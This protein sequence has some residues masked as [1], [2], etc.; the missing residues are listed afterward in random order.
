MFFIAVGECSG[1]SR[2]VRFHGL[3]L[4]LLGLA[5]GF[6]QAQGAADA[7]AV[8]ALPEVI[9]GAAHDEFETAD[10]LPLSHDTVP[11]DALEAGQARSV[12]QALQDLPNVSVRE[13][14]AR[15]GVSAASSAFARDG[16]SGI[17]IRGL[18]GNRVLMT[19]DGVR[20]PR[21]YVSR[22]AIFDREY[23]SLELFKRVELIRG[24]ASAIYGSDGLAGVVN[25][26][27]WEPRDFLA[28]KAGEPARAVG[29]RVSTGWSE[30]DHSH[31]LA[32]TVAGQL[33]EG[34]QWM[35]SANRRTAGPLQTMGS[36]GEAN[37]NRTLPNPQ[38]DGAN[39]VLG[40][41]VLRPH[42]GQRHGFTLEHT[43][44]KSA[45]ELL[46]SR[47]PVPARPNDILDEA[48]ASEV[49]RDRF[50]W[51]A[52]YDL[53][54]PLADSVRT[55]L[56]YQ[57]SSSQRVGT[58]ELFDGTHR[59]R[60]NWYG[61]RG[62]QAGL[63]AE[64]VL[65]DTGWTHR[66]VYGLDHVR[67]TIRNLYDGV[68]P[69]PPEAFPLKRFPDT[70]ETHSALYLQD[71]SVHG[72]WTITPG[73]RLDH[74]AIDVT[75]QAGYFP[76]ARQPGQSLS[77]A[78]AS[79]KFGVLY[80]MTPAWSVYG[81]YAAGFRPPE[82]GQLNDRFE[83]IAP[84]NT[85]VII[86]PNPNLKPEKSQGFELGLR[87]RM[88]RLSL[89]VAVFANRYSNLI[90]DAEFIQQVGNQRLFQAINV[91]RA[92]IHGIEVKGRYDWGRFAGGRLSSTFAWGMARGTDRS[93]GKPLNSIE[94][95]QATVGLR[96]DGARWSAWT[97]VRHHAAKKAGTIDSEAIMNA[98]A[99][100]QFATPA[101]TIL[102]V[103]LQW[104]PRQGVRVNLAVRNL[105]NRK[106]W[107]WPNVYG[108][109][110]NSPIRDAYSQPGRSAHLS[111]VMDF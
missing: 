106:Y 4:V 92:R 83:A 34:A 57:R 23:L 101:A 48:S 47:T 79:P 98:R 76:P 91:P 111:V 97:D 100:T 21:S 63:R 84:P 95:T 14:S 88:D 102:D 27:T 32:G 103:G 40:R 19:V 77:G 61:E 85:Q 75:S 73:L 10:E 11:G 16:N 80:R 17:S 45:V 53:G 29:G 104:R 3:C 69:L 66:L 108:V 28:G 64:K 15:V 58:G 2:L 90:V 56:A 5:C 7:G 72:D 18:G 62:W 94:P 13:T 33:G 26:V 109:A 41:L 93:S 52:S 43:R 25:F 31:S 96:V 42:A 67:S 36:N 59:V 38:H 20:L 105:T 68:A 89:D 30:E 82:A 1:L 24:P 22:S 49:G 70:R 37:A 55:I 9:I 54:A 87:G 8:G 86:Q 39:A 65:R 107:L 78:A 35:L 74:F 99:G 60:D 50:T 6:A 46:S 81:Q 51:D 44:K 110:S 71:E 12:G